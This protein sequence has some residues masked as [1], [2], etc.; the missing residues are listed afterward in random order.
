MSSPGTMP[1][2]VRSL[3][4]SCGR[5]SDG[6]GVARRGVRSSAICVRPLPLNARVTS[7]SRAGETK[8]RLA[9]LPDAHG[10]RRTPTAPLRRVHR[11][12][13]GSARTEGARGH[14]PN[15]V[16]ELV[17][18]RLHACRI[19]EYPVVVLLDMIESVVVPPPRVMPVAMIP[20]RRLEV[21]VQRLEPGR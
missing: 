20:L 8:C 11:L 2:V 5:C 10:D 12:E 7:S 1:S 4:C 19:R 6:F 3:A 13:R 21:L 18:P 9:R 14:C 15:E 17:C 16:S